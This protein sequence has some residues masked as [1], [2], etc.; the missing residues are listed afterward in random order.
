M[1]WHFYI[2]LILSFVGLFYLLR[3]GIGFANWVLLCIG[4][5]NLAIWALNKWHLYKLDKKR[6]K[7]K[8]SERHNIT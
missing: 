5:S 8:N 6:L 3:F 7:E 1:K 4:L 2:G